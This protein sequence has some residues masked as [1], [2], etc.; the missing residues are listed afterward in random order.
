MK[1]NISIFIVVILMFAI[2]FSG[3]SE[4]PKEN[5]VVL[6]MNYNGSRIEKI[7][8]TQ[9]KGGTIY[10]PADYKVYPSLVGDYVV[11]N[12]TWYINEAF[13]SN[14][15]FPCEMP[16][17]KIEFFAKVRKLKPVEQILFANPM[18]VNN[19]FSS[20]SILQDAYGQ[21]S[22]KSDT[23]YYEISETNVGTIKNIMRYYPATNT[24][25]LLRGYTISESFGGMAIIQDGFNIG[26][27]I[28]LNNKTI[29]C[30][31]IYSRTGYGQSSASG[32]N[33]I[34]SFNVDS[35]SL[36]VQDEPLFPNYSAIDYTYTLNNCT[37]YSKMKE[38][39]NSS[40]YEYAKK[41][42]DQ[43]TVLLKMM[44]NKIKVLQ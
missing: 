32:G 31:G 26:I 19:Y 11:L 20:N 13:T 29:V 43:S 9:R 8:T 2:V 18:D 39:W 33:V 7:L 42:Y 5:D 6:V 28:D 22:E 38:L 25:T 15:Y 23:S 24:I 37:N 14:A 16:A 34:I 4:E 27:S 44:N 3:C 30:K 21:P 1:K 12:D 41:C 35:V 17:T 10:N 40:G 36:D